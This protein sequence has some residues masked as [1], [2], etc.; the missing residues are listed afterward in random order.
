MKTRLNDLRD[1]AEYGDTELDK[2]RLALWEA[3]QAAIAILQLEYQVPGCQKLAEIDLYDPIKSIKAEK[4]GLKNRAA[5]KENLDASLPLGSSKTY[6]VVMEPG[7]HGGG[8]P[9]VVYRQHPSTD[10]KGKAPA[11]ALEPS[12]PF[13]DEEAATQAAMRASLGL[14]VI[15]EGA[16]SFSQPEEGWEEASL[17]MAITASLM[18]QVGASS[19]S[20]PRSLPRPSLAPADPDDGVNMADLDFD[21]I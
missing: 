14:Y 11:D 7:F 17:R 2:K 20:G 9:G 8:I 15:D 6:G 21:E 5:H 18:D 10:R 19:S 3:R 16:S 13:Y 1:S 12:S 4:R